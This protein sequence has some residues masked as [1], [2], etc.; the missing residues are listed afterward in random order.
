MDVC[1]RNGITDLHLCRV[2][3]NLERG[4]RVREGAARSLSSHWLAWLGHMN[5]HGSVNTT[6]GS[7]TWDILSVTL[8]LRGLPPDEVWEAVRY[9]SRG[10]RELKEC[11]KE[12]NLSESFLSWHCAEGEPCQAPWIS[13]IR[14][15]AF[16]GP[17]QS[18]RRCRW[19]DRFSRRKLQVTPSKVESSALSSSPRHP[20]LT[21]K[22]KN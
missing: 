21:L 9:T 11:E 19:Q 3:C 8:P 4:S 7:C 1:L 16:I 20:C 10:K 17:S 5:F 13:Y 18:H 12:G 14:E 6:A 22:S 2:I 15:P